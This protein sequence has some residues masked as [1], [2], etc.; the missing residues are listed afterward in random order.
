[1]NK[2]RWLNF[3]PETVS[4]MIEIPSTTLYQVLERTVE[5]YPDQR[6]VIDGEKEWSYKE[7]KN[8]VDQFAASLYSLGFKPGDRVA[9]MLP[10][11][12][13]YMIT[14]YATLRLGG[15]VV[16]ANPLYQVSELEYL[17]TNSRSTWF[18]GNDVQQ[19]KLTAIP[20]SKCITTIYVSH[21]VTPKD[22]QV[23]HFYEL[24]TNE[25]TIN[26]PDINI[27][28]KE[29]VAVIQY[30]G[31]T[32]GRSKGV[33]LTHYN[34]I[35]NIHQSFE[36]SDGFFKRP[37]ERIL[38]VIPFFHVYGMTGAMNLTIFAAGTI[39]CMKRFQIEEAISFIKKYRPTFFPGVPTMY[40][41]LLK[42][43]DSTPEILSSLKVCNSGSAPMPIEV[44]KEFESKTGSIIV[45]GYG[46][47]ETAP[48]THRNPVT[49]IKKQ[50]SIGIPLP[51]TDSK[52]VD[53][54]T[55][56][57]E[58]PPGEVGEL[59]IKGPQVMK[60]YW[61]N[62]KENRIAI[63]DG[64]LY[65]GDLATMDNDG[66]FFIV[67]RKK[68]LI[69]AS[70]YNVYPAEIEELLYQH[71]SIDEVCVFG[72][73]DPYRGETV[74]AVIVLKKDHHMTERDIMT[75]M[76]KRLAAYKVPKQ[77]SFRKELPK[78]A[79]GKVLRYK[80]VEEETEQNIQGKS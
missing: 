4:E 76:S 60:G 5:D 70:G 46:L 11:T 27:D 39:I 14:Y 65:T 51:N 47:S 28:A 77:I 2:K 16:Q 40:L 20:Y 79:V 32:T 56:T 50:G 52:V 59:I 24:L 22:E 44:M 7:L 35:A 45:E 75:W 33:M 69:I 61:E 13:E 43:P 54:A 6:A 49:G 21:E 37:G 80:L 48:I 17:L 18:V 66:Y 38:S 26:L 36:F 34:L 67:G 30:T 1:M 73:P 71:P 64:W 29:D 55:G 72:I 15:I 25:K 63:R 53:Q 9:L 68:D 12:V 74:K 3:Y 58:L 41:A 23:Y 31:G 19:K 57:T 42:H 8:S 78:T 62:E 10:N